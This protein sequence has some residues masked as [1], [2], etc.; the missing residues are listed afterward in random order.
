MRGRCRITNTVTLWIK[1]EFCPGEPPVST[2]HAKLDDHQLER[3]AALVD[4]DGDE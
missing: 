2:S 3:L 4:G 1:S